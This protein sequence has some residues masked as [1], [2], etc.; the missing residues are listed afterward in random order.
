MR[1]RF[2]AWVERQKFL[3]VHL[4]TLYRMLKPAII[5]HRRSLT[6]VAALLPISAVMATLIPY[7]TQRAVDDHILP[8]IDGGRDASP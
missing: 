3:S 6:L 2:R 8:A 1:N 4:P 7:L 5:E